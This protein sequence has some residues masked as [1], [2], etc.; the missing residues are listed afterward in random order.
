MISTCRPKLSDS[1]TLSY[2]KLLENHTL[3]S[4]TYLYSPYVAVP[5]VPLFPHQYIVY[6]NTNLLLS[7]NS[8]LSLRFQVAGCLL[9]VAGEVA[10]SHGVP[11]PPKKFL[12][13][14]FYRFPKGV[15]VPKKQ[16]SSRVQLSYSYYDDHVFIKENYN[17]LRH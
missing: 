3:H 2:S 12:K 7:T 5:P 1:Y 8:G 13:C 11:P 6:S 10:S 4:G 14:N 9:L 15:T 16:S 17:I